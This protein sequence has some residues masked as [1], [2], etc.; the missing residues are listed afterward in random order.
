MT[1]PDDGLRVAAVLAPVFRDAAGVLRTVLVVRAEDGSHGGQLGFPGGKP[2]PG[3]ADL[4]QTALREAHEEVG[5][6]PAQAVLL[7]QLDPVDTRASGYRVHAFAVRVPAE[8]EWRLDATEVV[9]LLTPPVAMLAD[10]AARATLPFTSPEFPDGL[11]V[12]G[13][14]VDGHVLWGMTLRLVDALA[15]RLL[16]GEWDV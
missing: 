16:A 4:L 14:D 2:E 3:D 13:V 10:P 11:L 5:L 8:T 9:G 1:A 15:P 12:D 6:D 7:G